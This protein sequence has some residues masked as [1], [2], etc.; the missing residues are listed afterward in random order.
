MK[1]LGH[2]FGV[3]WGLPY[4][5]LLIYVLPTTVVGLGH[6]IDFAIDGTQLSMESGH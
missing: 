1:K 5:I 4:F 2:G 3:E 6:S